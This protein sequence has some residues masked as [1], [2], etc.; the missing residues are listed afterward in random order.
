[1]EVGSHARFFSGQGYD[2]PMTSCIG[3]AGLCDY[4]PMGCAMKAHLIALWRSHFVLEEGMLEVDCSVLTPDYA[5]KSVL[6]SMT[7]SH[8]SAPSLYL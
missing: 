4:G 8:M 1:M 5:L 3:V 2:V 7:W 6:Y